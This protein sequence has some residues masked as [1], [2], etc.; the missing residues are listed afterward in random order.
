MSLQRRLAKF[1]RNRIRHYHPLTREIDSRIERSWV[2]SR[3]AV[4]N[5]HRYCY[6]RI[7][8]CANSTIARTL[9]CYDP[10]IDWDD[11]DSEGSRAK[12]T[13]LQLLDAQARSLDQLEERFFLFTFVRNPYTRLLSAYLDKIVSRIQD[14]DYEFVRTALGKKQKDNVSFPEFVSYL[15][16]GGLYANPH[17]APLVCMVGVKPIRL[18]FVGKVETIDADL[19]TIVTRIFGESVHAQTQTRT[20]G[21]RGANDQLQQYYTPEL[22]ASVYQLYRD[23]FAT[24][25]YPAS[26]DGSLDGPLS[27][28]L[29]A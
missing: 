5:T 23:D 28:T 25:G 27:G 12:R 16:S 9:A 11:A 13:F 7:P 20:H 3:A 4:S 10:A 22:A 18:Q 2:I 29:N 1:I 15:H 14:P 6:F 24:F 21:R 19:N 17:W 26:L 8:K